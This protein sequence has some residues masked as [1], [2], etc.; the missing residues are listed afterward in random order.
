M[1]SL[2]DWSEWY[3][4]NSKKFNAKVGDRVTIIKACKDQEFGWQNSWVFQMNQYV[5]R[6][7]IICDLSDMFGHGIDFGK[8]YREFSWPWFVLSIVR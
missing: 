8:G 3:I 2:T 6:T 5:G 1:I 4:I 7:G